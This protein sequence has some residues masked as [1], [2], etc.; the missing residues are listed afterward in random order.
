MTALQIYA[1]YIAPL[2]VLA[3]GAA[4]FWLTSPRPHRD[5]HR[6]T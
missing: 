2:V 1:F 6:D 3:I 4:V 5:R